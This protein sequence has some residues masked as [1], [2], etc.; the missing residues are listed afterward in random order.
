METILLSDNIQPVVS[1]FC[2]NWFN[3]IAY[4]SWNEL[5]FPYLQLVQFV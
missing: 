3:K 2:L 5:T 4:W 1:L